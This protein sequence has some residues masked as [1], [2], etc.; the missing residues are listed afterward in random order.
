MK[1]QQP[2]P[3]HLKV[4]K[5]FKMHEKPGM[6]PKKRRKDDSGLPELPVLKFTNMY[7]K[8]TSG[9]LTKHHLNN[10]YK[11]NKNCFFAKTLPQTP[12]P[13]F[14]SK[15]HLLFLVLCPL[16]VPFC[17][18]P[19]PVQQGSLLGARSRRRSAWGRAAPRGRSRWVPRWRRRCPCG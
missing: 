3:G 16:F 14:F 18:S 12:T 5:T 13:V 10:T 4:A 6:I 1:P 15:K 7:N 19:G 8:K 17:G 9:H 2:Q 11:I